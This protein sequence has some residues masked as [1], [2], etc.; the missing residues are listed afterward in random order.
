ML[1]CFLCMRRALYPH[2]K[3]TYLE[4]SEQATCAA[5]ICEMPCAAD[6]DSFLKKKD[7]GFVEALLDLIQ[8]SGH[9]NSTI[10]KR[11]NM[12]KQHFSKLINNPGVAP[13]KPTAI[14]LAL[15]LELDLAQTNAL[16]GRA[17]YTLTNSSIFDLIIQYYIE[18]KNYN[19]VEIN[20]TLYEFDQ[21]LLGS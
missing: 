4:K 5:S 18:R 16:L 20:I 17:G 7:T 15:A 13:T 2:P 3:A 11:A 6:L 10:Y 9:K 19:I 21:S 14:A 12:S 1:T 8:K